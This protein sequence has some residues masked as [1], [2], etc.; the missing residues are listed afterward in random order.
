MGRHS[1]LATE[2]K[3]MLAAFPTLSFAHGYVRDVSQ[4]IKESRLFTAKSSLRDSTARI[5]NEE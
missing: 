4:I 3:V 2:A 5:K 1:E